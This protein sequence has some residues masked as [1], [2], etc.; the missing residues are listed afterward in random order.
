MYSTPFLFLFTFICYGNT[1]LNGLVLDDGIYI[2]AHQTVQR[3]ISGIPRLFTE[4][5]TYGFIEL[6]GQQPY[7]PLPLV[8]FAIGKSLYDNHPMV[9]HAINV[10]LFGLLGLILFQLLQYWLPH[11]H[12]FIRMGI[13]LLFLAHPIHTEVVANV[14]SRDEILCF[15]FGALSIKYLQDFVRGKG[16][17]YM[18]YSSV[19]FL[20]AILSKESGLTLLGVFP[21]VL[22]TFEKR[23]LMTSIRVLPAYLLAMLLYLLIR[24][25]VIKD[26]VTEPQVDIINNV[27]HGADSLGV[28]TATVFAL[29]GNY[30][31]LLLWPHPLS[32]DY[33]YNQLP[34]VNWSSLRAWGSL[35]FHIGLVGICISSLRRRG[36][37]GFGILFY[38]LTMAITSNVFFLNGATLG[39]RFLFMPSWAFCLLFPLLTLQ[40]LNI[41]FK[42]LQG[43]NNAVWQIGLAGLIVLGTVLTIDRNQDWRSDLSL[44]E[45]G[46]KAVPHSARAHASLAFE[47]KLQAIGASTPETQQTYF[48]R[49]EMAFARSLEIYP[50]FE[51]ALYN[52]GVLYLEAGF[53][54]NARV[55]F[56]KLLALFPDH[57]AGLNNMGVS[58][59]RQ[60]KY[61]EAIPYFNHL[62]EVKPGHH[63]ALIN[64]GASYFNLNE[65][66]NALAYYE[67]SLVLQQ[68][69]ASTYAI[70]A[71]I[72]QALGQPEKAA[73]Y[74]SRSN[75]LEQ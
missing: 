65:M 67:R 25:L 1:L 10:L 26:Q 72:Y 53:L 19:L 48:R 27:L 42:K 32:W 12:I 30:L 55:H 62:L 61:V 28:R 23:S 50:Q 15:L 29:L 35:V 44:F 54:E 11:H 40:W 56:A 52:F 17:A 75:S 45:A 63:Q 49:A 73:Q 39:E 7:R 21:L 36:V 16:N 24:F 60:K 47:Y 6:Q 66:E 71:R 46:V 34:L 74:I 8:S 9:E 68:E 38:V 31:S 14:K 5:S 59:F 2:K 20:A 69:T 4:G 57:E 33:S 18:V 22:Y 64:L 43:K 41:D 70:L 58:Y 51:Y 3:G 13:V 37:I